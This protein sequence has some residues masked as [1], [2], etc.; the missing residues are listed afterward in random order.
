MDA[1]ER[2][3][4]KRI[5]RS[6]RTDEYMDAFATAQR[7]RRL[8]AAATNRGMRLVHRDMAHWWLAIAEERR[9]R[10][11]NHWIDMDVIDTDM[12][13]EDDRDPNLESEDVDVGHDGRC[14]CGAI[15][16][17]EEAGCCEPAG[18]AYDCPECLARH[19]RRGERGSPG[20]DHAAGYID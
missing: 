12:P 18:H 20:Y 15:V 10:R 9:Q 4:L 11:A 13:D 19:T 7:W 6:K 14:A 3:T 17:C 8:M 1:S 2:R 5:F 16:P